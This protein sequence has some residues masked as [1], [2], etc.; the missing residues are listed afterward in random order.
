MQAI[1]FKV[2]SQLQELLAIESTTS[3]VNLMN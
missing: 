2:E 3:F 1:I